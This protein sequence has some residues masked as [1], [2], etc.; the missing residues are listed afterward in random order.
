MFASLF[1]GD[2]NDFFTVVIPALG[3][4]IMRPLRLLTLRAGRNIDR[5]KGMMRPALITP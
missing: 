3:A 5:I 2:G 4:G 1:G